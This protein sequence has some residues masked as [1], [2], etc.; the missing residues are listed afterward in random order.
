MEH[1]G[2]RQQI[3]NKLAAARETA[4][5]LAGTLT[6]RTS[7]L[8]YASLVR[9]V[10]GIEIWTE[11]LRRAVS[12]HEIIVI[13]PRDEPYY[14]DGTVVLPSD[15]RIEASGSTLKLTP[16]CDVLMFITASAADG[17]HAPID[18]NLNPPVHNISIHGG[19][20]EE[21]RTRR[22]GYGT[23][24]KNDHERS[25]HG[26]S[27]LFYLGNAENIMMTDVTIAHTAGF[28]VQTGNVI[29][30]FFE[31]IRFEHCYADGLHINGNTENLLCRNISGQVGDDIVALNAYDWQNS[32][33]NFGPIVTVLCENLELSADSPYKA[34]RIEPGRYWYDDGL[35]VDCALKN[36][37]LRDI[38][39]IRTFKLYYQTP[40]YRIG[41]KP[42]RGDVGSADN[43]FFE[44]ITIDL[45]EPIDGFDVYKNS[46]PVRGCFAAFEL[47][48]DIGYMRLENIR[49]NLYKGKFPYSCLVCC[50]PKSVLKGGTEIFDPYLSSRVRRLDLKAITVNAVPAE[51]AEGLTREIVFDDVDHDD[52]S[53][54]RGVFDQ[55]KFEK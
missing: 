55:I 7:L 49:I 12:E 26:I 17:T 3:E 53:T 43:L 48:A 11:A 41:G 27:T 2:I 13:P 45:S 20:F 19:K 38:R 30:A 50:G 28:A 22:G 1:S 25:M 31:N 54:A 24:G 4:L 18:R 47:G 9:T 14:I 15:R 29:G 32:S 5:N 46:D 42:E 44:D 52:N 6:D 37:I 10:N 39:G 35:G 36:A 21:S 33:V 16:D 34:I 51:T 40:P 8:D 23:S